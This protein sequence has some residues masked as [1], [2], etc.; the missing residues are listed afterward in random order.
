MDETSSEFKGKQKKGTIWKAPFL[1]IYWWELG[2]S[3]S[4]FII[5]IWVIIFDPVLV[6]MNENEFQSHSITRWGGGGAQN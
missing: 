3:T 6:W 1:M 5:I 4:R 2:I